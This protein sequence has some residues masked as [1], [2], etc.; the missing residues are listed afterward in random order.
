MSLFAFWSSVAVIL[1]TYLLF[2]IILA[3]RAAA[4]GDRYREA[5]IVPT[6]SHNKAPHNQARVIAVKQAKVQSL[7]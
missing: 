5:D 4:A 2:P 1:Y 3:V 7:D 6:I